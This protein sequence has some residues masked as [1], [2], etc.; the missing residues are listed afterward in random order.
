MNVFWFFVT[1]FAVA[2]LNGCAIGVMQ[3]AIR[4]DMQ[5]LVFSLIGSATMAMTPLGL[6]IAGP[7]ADAAGVPV[8][9]LIGGVVTAVLM[10]IGVLTPSVL[11]LEDVI[12]EQP[13]VEE[14]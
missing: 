4:A 6:I 12:V 8:W 11:K 14:K 13:K 7:V 5:G 1:G 10:V 9:F 3:T 2:V